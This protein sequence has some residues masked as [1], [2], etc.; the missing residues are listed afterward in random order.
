MTDGNS[1]DVSR[2]GDFT[3]LEGSTVDEVLKR[4]P[5]D[6]SMRGLIPV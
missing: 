1:E 2:V 6:V 3:E 5:E 4:I